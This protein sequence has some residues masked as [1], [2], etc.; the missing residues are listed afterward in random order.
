MLGHL[1]KQPFVMTTAVAALIHSTWALGVL[2]AGH[3]PVPQ[4]TWVYPFQ[5]MYWLLPALMIAISLDVGQ[6]AT[7]MS[8]RKRPTGAKYATFIVFAVA[9]YYLQFIYMAYHMPVLEASQAISG[10]HQYLMNVLLD[11]ALWVIPSLLPLS[12]TLYTFSSDGD[13]GHH[14]VISNLVESSPIAIDVKPDVLAVVPSHP[15]QEPLPGVVNTD[16]IQRRNPLKRIKCTE[17]G[18]TFNTRTQK[19]TCSD[20]TTKNGNRLRKARQRVDVTQGVEGEYV[21]IAE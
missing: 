18:T 10:V 14:S 12:T 6:V 21:S 5:L 17:C 16:A 8:I 4:A 15:I 20:C 19:T 3:P 1:K 2:F 7:A 13:D 11:M 9:T